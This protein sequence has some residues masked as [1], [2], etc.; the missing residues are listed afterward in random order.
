MTFKTKTELRTF[1]KKEEGKKNLFVKK[2]QT[3]QKK[4]ECS[5]DHRWIHGYCRFYQE[6]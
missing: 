2:T 6:F 1:Q 5:F 3:S 4:H